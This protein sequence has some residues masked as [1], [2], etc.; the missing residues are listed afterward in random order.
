MSEGM[1]APWLGVRVVTVPLREVWRQVAGL[2]VREAS[3]M[4]SMQTGSLH[5]S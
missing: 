3:G 1:F 4:D 2:G 5:S